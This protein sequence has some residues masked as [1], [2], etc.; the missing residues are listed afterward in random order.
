MRVLLKVWSDGVENAD[1][2]LVTIEPP[3]ALRLLEKVKLAED[4]KTGYRHFHQLTFF[5]LWDTK[6]TMFGS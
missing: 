3:Y 1:Y 2:A 4:V 5:V 6:H